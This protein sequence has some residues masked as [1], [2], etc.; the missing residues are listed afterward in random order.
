MMDF[1]N[2]QRELLTL[3]EEMRE[4]RRQKAAM[5]DGR[6][7]LEE[8]RREVAR[9]KAQLSDCCPKLKKDLTNLERELATLKEE[10]TELRRQKAAMA[11]EQEWHEREICD[12]K[13]AVKLL[14]MAS[15]DQQE[16][17]DRETQAV[18]EVRKVVGQLAGQLKDLR[19]ENDDDRSR[20]R[21]LTRSNERLQGQVV[22]LDQWI[23]LLVREYLRPSDA[24]EVVKRYIGQVPD[25]C[26]EFKEDLT[27]L[28]QELAKLKKEVRATRELAK[29]GGLIG[30]LFPIFIVAI[31]TR[32]RSA[33]AALG[34]KTS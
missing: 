2:L 8:V 24:N 9:Q 18:A 4:L 23:K 20:F 31:Q 15:D 34:W 26:P 29:A 3:K 19:S 25:C 27:Y 11:D 14:Q 17:Q 33:L 12:V 13:H 1:L 6:A 16:S 10:M 32:F 22:L 30:V 28:E 5:A 7:K 21:D